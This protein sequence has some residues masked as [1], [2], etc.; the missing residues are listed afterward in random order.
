MKPK[1]KKDEKKLADREGGRAK[2]GG[3]TSP[4]R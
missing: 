4:D 3:A 2:Y 1:S